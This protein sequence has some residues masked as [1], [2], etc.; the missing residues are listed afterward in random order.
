[1]LNR[2]HPPLRSAAMLAAD[3]QGLAMTEFAFALPVLMTLALGGLEVANLALAHLRVNQVAVTTADNA[4]RVLTQMDETD[5]DEVF[6]GAAV[7]AAG[8]DIDAHG[9]VVLSS[10]QDNG[11]PPTSRGQ[12]INWQRCFGR[13][14]EPPRYGRQ[15]QGRTDAS[16]RDGMGPPGRRILAQPGTAVMFVEVTYDYQPLVFGSVIGPQVIRY[17]SAYNVRERTELNITNLRS[18]PVRNC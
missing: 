8:I 9:R 6:A 11:R 16:M 4:G 14:A 3:R 1:M 18:R 2:P 17:E 13:K 15:N 7:A 5:V 10:L 12:M